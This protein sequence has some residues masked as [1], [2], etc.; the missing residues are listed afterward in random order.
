MTGELSHICN[1]LQSDLER[2][3]G[4]HTPFGSVVSL[5]TEANA[6]FETKPFV[7]KAGAR[8]SKANLSTKQRLTTQL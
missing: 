2:S 3:Q 8:N 1:V 4:R 5:Q 6:K 7:L